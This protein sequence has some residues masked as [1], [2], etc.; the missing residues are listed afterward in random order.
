MAGADEDDTTLMTVAADDDAAEVTGAALDV[1]GALET[2]AGACP[3]L[4]VTQSAR[5][6]GGLT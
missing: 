4:G 6:A 1:V 3:E 5:N 2:A